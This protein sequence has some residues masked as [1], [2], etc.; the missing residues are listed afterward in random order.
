MANSGLWSKACLRPISLN[1]TSYS[2]AKNST[3]KRQMLF[4]GKEGNSWGSGVFSTCFK[5]KK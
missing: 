2:L 5:A 3:L 1:S 4:I